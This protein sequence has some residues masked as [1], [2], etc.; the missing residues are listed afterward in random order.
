MAL[1]IIWFL[2]LDH[3]PL[4]SKTLFTLLYLYLQNTPN[5]SI[6]PLLHS[7]QLPTKTCGACFSLTSAHKIHRKI[8]ETR[9]K[10]SQPL[11][12][13]P[14]RLIW[15]AKP[16]PLRCSAGPRTRPSSESGGSD[17][18]KPKTGCPSRGRPGSPARGSAPPRRRSHGA[19]CRPPGRPRSPGSSSTRRRPSGSTGSSRS[20]TTT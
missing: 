18:S 14:S 16:W 4:S 19:A 20:C 6:C 13:G 10:L 12:S 1:F 9:P 8:P 17:S 5:P 7:S 11:V 15:S 2:I 3:S